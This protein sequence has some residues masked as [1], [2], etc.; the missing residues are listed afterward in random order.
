MTAH[1]SS[2]RPSAWSN[3][4]CVTSNRET[5]GSALPTMSFSK[6]SLS[7]TTEPSGGFC[8]TTF[9]PLPAAAFSSAIL[10]AMVC[11]GAWMMTCPTVS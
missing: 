6:V 8:F 11:S 3:I 5:S 9:P 4:P 2:S 1:P 7:Q 10:L